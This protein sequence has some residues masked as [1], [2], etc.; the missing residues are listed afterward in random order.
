MNF[1]RA[2]QLQNKVK[3]GG[4][5]LKHALQSKDLYFQSCE[6]TKISRCGLHTITKEC[7][8][9]LDFPG[10]PHF[11]VEAGG[12]RTSHGPC[13]T[14]RHSLIELHGCKMFFGLSSARVRSIKYYLGFSSWLG[15]FGHGSA[16][17]NRE[18]ISTYS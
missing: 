2:Q 4:T 18:N 9:T 10:E 17:R 11:R 13:H 5:V 6:K 3:Q 1:S 12:G 7:V 14:S 8:D 16:F 15:D